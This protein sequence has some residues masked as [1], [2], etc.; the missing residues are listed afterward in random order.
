MQV[1]PPTPS[2]VDPLKQIPAVYNV[3]YDMLKIESEVSE[4]WS[5]PKFVSVEHLSVI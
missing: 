2:L 1:C 3:G 5:L 4:G